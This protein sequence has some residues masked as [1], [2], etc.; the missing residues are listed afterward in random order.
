MRTLLARTTIIGVAILLLVSGQAGAQQS[1]SPSRSVFGP[2][3]GS[4]LRPS[5]LSP[6]VN[7][8]VGSL[9]GFDSLGNSR[10]RNGA[11]EPPNRRIPPVERGQDSLS[12]PSR[13]GARGYF[14]N[15]SHYYNER[16][17][18]TRGRGGSTSR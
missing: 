4:N 14:M 6:S 15:Y 3:L 16:G 10:F 9:P 17:N 5:P 8:G 1:G 7:T 11:L 13:G 18:G 2:T 12:T